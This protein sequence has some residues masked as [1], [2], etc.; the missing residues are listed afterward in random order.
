MIV[1]VVL[2]TPG[3]H[4]QI[5]KTNA[6]TAVP[7]QGELVTINDVTRT[8]HSVAWDLTEMSATIFLNE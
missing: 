1:K 3:Q 8:V 6:M 7:R 5:G 4:Q 2:R